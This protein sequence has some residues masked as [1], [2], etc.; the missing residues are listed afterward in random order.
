MSEEETSMHQLQLDQ[1]NAHKIRLTT[2]LAYANKDFIYYCCALADESY[3]LG[4]V[5]IDDEGR[6]LGTREIFTQMRE[7][8]FTKRQLT[9]GDFEQIDY[10]LGRIEEHLSWIKKRLENLKSFGTVD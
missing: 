5:V 2:D 8:E 7:L 1:M 3:G 4:R 9:K 10:S 6:R